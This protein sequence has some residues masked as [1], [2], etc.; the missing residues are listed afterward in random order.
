MHR[1]V[2]TVAE[3]AGARK[4]GNN[5]ITVR[6]ACLGPGFGSYALYARDF[7]VLT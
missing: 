6:E 1:D 3:V 5:S 4:N 2:G 7:V